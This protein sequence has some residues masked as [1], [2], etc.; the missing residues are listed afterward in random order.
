MFQAD[1]LLLA[2]R[3]A[4][5]RF[6]VIGG[7]AVGVHGYVRATKDLDMVPDPDPKYFT[8]LAALLR[9]LGAERIGVGE[10]AADEFQYDPTNPEQLTQGADFRLETCL[11]AARHHAVGRQGSGRIRRTRRSPREAIKVPFRGGATARVWAG[12]SPRDEDGRRS[13][14]G[15]ARPARARAT[16]SISVDLVVRQP[17]W[18]RGRGVR[19]S[20]G[21]RRD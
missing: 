4:Q 11:R 20:V 7:I 18:E 14:R 6:I 13:R 5:V 12:S 10:F 8:R 16:L 3:R 17:N 2:L 19:A 15:S 21:P 9:E 1:E